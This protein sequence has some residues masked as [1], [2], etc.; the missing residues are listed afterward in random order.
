MKKAAGALVALV[1]VVVAGHAIASWQ[2][3]KALESAVRGALTDAQILSYDRGVYATH[4]RFRI[5]GVLGQ[6][7]DDTAVIDSSM[8]HGPLPWRRLGQGHFTPV[9]AATAST[10][11]ADEG[12]GKRLVSKDADARIR[13]HSTLHR[14]G[15]IESQIDVPAL[16]MTGIDGELIE[17]GAGHADVTHHGEV[18]QTLIEGELASISMDSGTDIQAD[19]FDIKV[20][21][22]LLGRGTRLPTGNI[23]LAAGKFAFSSPTPWDAPITLDADSVSAFWQVR[24]N[25]AADDLEFNYELGDVRLGDVAVGGLSTRLVASKVDSA[26]LRAFIS[27]YGK[28]KALPEAPTAPDAPDVSERAPLRVQAKQAWAQMLAHTP[29]LALD[30]LTWHAEPGDSSLRAALTVLACPPE[31]PEKA[32][33]DARTACARGGHGSLDLS[34]SQPAVTDLFARVM[35]APETGDTPAMR[36]ARE[37]AAQMIDATVHNFEQAGV[38][39]VQD[40]TIRLRV[41]G[42]GNHVT[43]NDEPTTYENLMDLLPGLLPR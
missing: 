18:D 42:D 23:L 17:V 41:S 2:A 20:R 13:E 43:L 6:G 4:A 15:R 26:G 29:E 25:G 37:Q 33:E 14:G 3:G 35:A 8:Q 1:T 10:L 27:T 7:D 36:E 21:G 38:V 31:P 24:A 22:D 11:S 28:L 19:L 16:T 39:M 5:N 30:T 40:G 34:L 32:G 9:L 12:W